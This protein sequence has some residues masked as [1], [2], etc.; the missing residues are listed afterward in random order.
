LKEAKEEGLQIRN[1]CQ[2]MIKKY[3][4]SFLNQGSVLQVIHAFLVQGYHAIGFLQF[5]K[6]Q[7]K[8]FYLF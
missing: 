2:A 7:I 1:D 3:Q 6:P 8:C 5:Y 4:A